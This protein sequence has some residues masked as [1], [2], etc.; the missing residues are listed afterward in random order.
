MTYSDMLFKEPTYHYSF[1]DKGTL[2]GHMSFGICFG[3]FG[4]EVFGWVRSGNHNR[5]VGEIGLAYAEQIAF[6][7]KI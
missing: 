6:T 4:A 7:R 2:L 3:Q 5:G 1:F